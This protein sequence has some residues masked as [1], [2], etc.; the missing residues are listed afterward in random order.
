MEL[1]HKQ[2]NSKVTTITRITAYESEGILDIGTDNTSYNAGE[3]H[4]L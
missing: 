3:H 1:S 4:K 2:V